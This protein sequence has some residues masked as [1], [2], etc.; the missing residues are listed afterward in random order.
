MDSIDNETQQRLAIELNGLVWK[1]LGLPERTD[2]ENT[3][4]VNAAHASAWHWSEV[5]TAENR[6]RGE[7]LIAHVY[8]VLNMP[9]P[10]I[11]H[12]NRCME[13]TRANDL[14]GFDLAY[15]CEGLARA[16]ACALDREKCVLYYGHAENAAA[17]IPDEEDRNI[18]MN[19]LEAEP[20]YRMR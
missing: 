2:E 4:M 1:M 5:G 18:F 7:W 16:S 8:S 19:D 17:E 12:A 9:A 6:A 10:A 11:F 15:A 20:W 3:R 13:I 14:K